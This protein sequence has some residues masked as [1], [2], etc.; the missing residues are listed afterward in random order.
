MCYARQYCIFEYTPRWA[1]N[2]TLLGKEHDCISSW[3]QFMDF[4]VLCCNTGHH[5]CQA[6]WRHGHLWVGSTNRKALNVET[7]AVVVV[8]TFAW[9]LLRRRWH[10]QSLSL[11]N[12]CHTNMFRFDV[13]ENDAT[14]L[15][16]NLMSITPMR[17]QHFKV[18]SYETDSPAPESKNDTSNTYTT[19]RLSNLT[20]PD[21]MPH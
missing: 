16:S 19:S 8:S 5:A 20:C 3:F 15:C 11:W 7:D 2:M 1:K 18:T 12:Q 14:T 21:P 13:Y 6:T 9:Q 10:V 4:P 17:H